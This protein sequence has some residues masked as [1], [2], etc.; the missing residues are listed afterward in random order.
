MIE[1]PPMTAF[2]SGTGPTLMVPSVATMVDCCRCTPAPKIQTYISVF[3][4][5][6]ASPDP[7]RHHCF[8]AE[9]QAQVDRFHSAGVAAG[10]SSEGAPGLRQYHPQYYAAFLLDPEGNKLEAVFH[11]GGS[12]G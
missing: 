1:N 3:Q 12:G 7:R 8:R 10:G 6:A 11:R 2:V 9:S 4:S 5:P